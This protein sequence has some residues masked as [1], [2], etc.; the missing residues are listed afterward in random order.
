MLWGGIYLGLGYLQHQRA[1]AMGHDIAAARGHAPSP[2]A[3]QTS[4]ANLLVWKVL[5]ETAEDYHAG[6]AARRWPGRRS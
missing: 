2:S 6:G 1:I 5:Y 3:S 4:F